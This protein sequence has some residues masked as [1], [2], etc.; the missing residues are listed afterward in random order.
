M[1]RGLSGAGSHSLMAAIKHRMGANSGDE[2]LGP[3]GPGSPRVASGEC[4]G[5]LAHVVRRPKNHSSLRP[6]EPSRL[7]NALS[8]PEAVELPVGVPLLRP[9]FR[10][11]GSF[12]LYLA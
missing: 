8:Q 4:S 2:D 12:F 9:E 10:A 3:H 6:R 7:L 5:M 11:G 1:E